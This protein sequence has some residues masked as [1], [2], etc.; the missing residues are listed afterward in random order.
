MEQGAHWK[1]LPVL[2]AGDPQLRASAAFALGV[3]LPAR[4]YVERG[5][6][7]QPMGGSP[8]SSMHSGM[9]NGLD[10]QMGS[11][12][13]LPVSTATGPAE[14]HAAAKD[15]PVSHIYNL[16]VEYWKPARQ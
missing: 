15:M 3:L 16:E 7:P 8:H 2:R 5:Q 14:A 6:Q 11:E 1:L 10:S 4:H 12:T 13:I 9:Y